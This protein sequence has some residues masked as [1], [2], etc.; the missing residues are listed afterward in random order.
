MTALYS[1]L[2]YKLRQFLR[3]SPD[4]SIHPQVRE[5]FRRNF[6]VNT[7]DGAFWM[8][9]DS[10]VSVATILPVFASTLTD[11]PIIIGLVPALINAGWFIPQLFMAGYVKQLPRK[12]PFARIMAAVERAPFLLLPLTAFL[13]PWLP[14]SVALILF[15]I[16][17][18]LRG[19]ASGMVAL[20]WQE[21]IASV[22]PSAVRSRFFGISRTLARIFAVFGSVAASLILGAFPYPNNYGISFLLGA[23]FIWV[24][25]FFFIRTIEPDPLPTVNDK[26]EVKKKLISIDLSDFKSILK[27]DVN[28][29]KYLASRSLFQLGNM[30]TSFFA[31]YGIKQFSLGDQQAGIF[32]AF[33]FT[34][35]I[36]GFFL[37]GIFGDRIGPRMIL[38][39]SDL[40][41]LVVLVLAIL[42]PAVWFFYLVFL[43]LGFAQAGLIIGELILGMELGTE[44]DRP[45]YLGLARTI[46]GI[47][48][49]IAPIIGGTLVNW[50]GYRMM[51]VIA[52]FMTVVGI[53]YLL[54]LRERKQ[55]STQV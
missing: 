23:V 47:F 49:L 5:H 25:F 26:V 39:I 21:V 54:L 16:G 3:L 11:S 28:F 36:F 48:I 10:F 29:R 22:I 40:L 55:L 50:I 13:L 35:S 17:V 24:S 8:L 27:R 6:F 44:E 31:V 38:I 12:L 41:Q 42:A 51:F 9:G 37:W 7:M 15:I 1:R 18:T 20:P 19:F 4:P 46:P 43:I 2:L 34:S 53:I 32:S 52:I 14:K 30:A 33:L 45:T